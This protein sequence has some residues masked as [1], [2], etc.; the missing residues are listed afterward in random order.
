MKKQLDQWTGDFGRAYTE[1]NVYD[2]KLRVPAF[3]AMLKDLSLERVLEVGCNRGYNL[4]ALREVLGPG[5]EI[6]GVEPNAFALEIARAASPRVAAVHGD[7][8]NLPFPDASFDLV[9]TV[10]VLI[11]IPPE[12][13]PK[14][15]TEIHRV[16]RRYI[17]AAEYYA[18]EETPIVYRGQ[19]DLLWKRD[20]RQHYQTLFPGLRLLRE[21]YW[22]AEQGFD[23]THWWLLEK[24]AG[25]EKR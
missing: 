2:W 11:H 23:R 10:G 16:S 5:P 8:Y 6:V 17:L 25:A 7:A 3:R 21:G 9:F 4:L 15:L 18:A 20:F 24:P 14:A 1:R 12:E 19:N 22:D 13:L